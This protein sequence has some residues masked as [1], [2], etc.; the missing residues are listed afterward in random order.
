MARAARV[1]TVDRAA[2]RRALHPAV[3]AD[4]AVLAVFLIRLTMPGE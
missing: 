1:A 2:E 4:L 3:P